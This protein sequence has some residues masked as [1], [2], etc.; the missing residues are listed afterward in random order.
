MVKVEGKLQRD[1]NYANLE[2]HVHSVKNGVMYKKAM[3]Q[4]NISHTGVDCRR[5]PC[6]TGK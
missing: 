5:T 4:I 1:V 6:I 3:N 2:N